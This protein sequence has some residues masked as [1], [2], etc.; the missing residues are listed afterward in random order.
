MKD[1]TNSVSALIVEKE[2]DWS[3]FTT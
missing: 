3:E 1:P 2:A